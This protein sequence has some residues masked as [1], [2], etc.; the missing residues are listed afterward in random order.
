VVGI[1]RWIQSPYILSIKNLVL[2]AVNS[3]FGL[4]ACTETNPPES[5]FDFLTV[6]TFILQATTPTEIGAIE[7]MEE[8]FRGFQS[9]FVYDQ[10][11]LQEECAEI[12]SQLD[13]ERRVNAYRIISN[14][15]S[16]LTLEEA[17]KF[18]VI[19]DMILKG[20]QLPTPSEEE[21]KKLF[22]E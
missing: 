9:T 19:F 18:S 16:Q 12:R 6:I 1:N 5:P 8:H 14:G 15:F 2:R 3:S 4:Y 22:Q 7:S 13:M 11:K 17:K 10:E 21:I 20:Q